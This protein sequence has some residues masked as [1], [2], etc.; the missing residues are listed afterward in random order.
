MARRLVDRQIEDLD[1]VT[2]RIQREIERGRL[3]LAYHLALSIPEALPS[4]N[5]IKLIACNYLA[6]EQASIP[7]NLSALVG[8]LVSEVETLPNGIVDRGTLLNYA[9]L[10]TSAALKPSL[11]VPGSEEVA[12]LF[13]FSDGCLAETPS[14]QALA[15]DAAEVSRRR[16]HV[17]LLREDDSRWSE[18][19]GRLRDD[20][21]DWL[22]EE[23]SRKNLYKR[24]NYVWKRMLEVWEFG[25]RASIGRLV[26]L[27]V[28]ESDDRI[29]IDKVSKITEY[30]RE[31][32]DKEIDRIDSLR[33]KRRDKIAGVSRTLLIE[34]IEKAL[35]FADRWCRLAE[36]RPDKS[37]ESQKSHADRLRNSVRKNAE[38]AL[39]EISALETPYAHEARKL[40]RGYESIFENEA[41][42]SPRPNLSLRDL[43]HG[44]LLADPDVRFDETDSV[45]DSDILQGLVDRD[46][47]DFGEA[48]VERARRKDFGGAEKTLEFAERSGQI[49]EGGLTGARK[50]IEKQQEGSR[51]ELEGRIGATRDRLDAAHAREIL[52]GEVFEELHDLLPELL[53]DRSDVDEYG[54]YSELLDLIKKEIH[55]AGGKERDRLKRSLDGLKGAS[56]EE[57]NRIE[58]LIEDDQF[59]IAQDYINR[60]KYRTENSEKLPEQGSDTKHTFDRFFPKFVEKYVEYRDETPDALA[61]VQQALKDRASAGPVNAVELSPDAA[62]DGLQL[63]EKWSDLQ[64]NPAVPDRLRDLM[65]A[66]GFKE[67]KIHRSGTE[68]TSFVLETDPVEDRSI[69]QLPDFGSRARGRYRLIVIRKYE[70]EEILW[71]AEEKNSAG[72]LPNIVIFLNVLGAEARRTLARKFNSGGYRPTI[73]F[74]EVFVAFLAAQPGS[75]RHRLRAFF[76]CAAPFSFAQPFD[77]HADEVPLEMFFG[78]EA[79]RNKIVSASGNGTHFVY[80]GRRMGKTALF[81]DIARQN[82]A[83]AP[84]ELVLRIDLRNTGIGVSK[85]AE[86]LWDKFAE[87]LQMIIPSGPDLIGEEIKRWLD[88]KKERRILL[89]VDEAD[90]FL[91]A[92]GR[93]EVKVDGEEPRRK[94]YQIV[95][96]VKSLMNETGRRFRVVFGGLHNVQ[97]TVRDSN[98]PFAHFDD[99][100][101][102]G[103]M[104]PGTDSKRIENLILGPMEAL[105]YRFDSI[106]SVIRIAAE[107]NYD[108]A[109]VQCFCM[110]LLDHL[111]KNSGMNGAL[112][113]PYTIS[114]E[115][116]DRICNSG[117]IRRRIKD[118]FMWTLHLDPRYEFLTYLIARKSFDNGS[119]RLGDLSLSQIRQDALKE[120]FAGFDL[121]P[122]FASFEVL[123][124]E[125]VGLGVLRKRTNEEDGGDK[126]Y[127]IRTR[128]LRMLLGNDN[129]IERGFADAKRRT[130]PPLF[131]PAGFRRTLNDKTPSPLTA[132]QEGRLF[133][134]QN[135]VALVFGT[136]LSGIDQVR[137]ALDWA[138]KRSPIDIRLHEDDSERR[139]TVIRD[140]KP[141]LDV[142]LADMRGAWDSDRIDEALAYVDRN[143]ASTRTIRMVFLCGPGEAWAWVKLSRPGSKRRNAELQ[144]IWLG[145]YAKDFAIDWLKE[146]EA[147]VYRDD[148]KNRDPLWPVVAGKAAGQERPQERPE[149]VGAA[150]DLAIEG[151][152]MVSDILVS[153]EVEAALRT[154]SFLDSPMN[155]DLL[156]QLSPD[157]E[158][159]EQEIDPDDARRVFEWGARLGIMH[160]VGEREGQPEYRLDAAYAK[161]LEAVFKG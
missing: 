125:M 67:V 111:R 156:A 161:G 73:V 48:A 150:V 144:D 76:D 62:G 43:L 31:N 60:I 72:V 9:V 119:S 155:M 50:E 118:M 53:A 90:D 98:A 120:W 110:E 158:G 134:P 137:E 39:E 82:R 37:T 107:A 104:L 24:A 71:E 112:G 92:D 25:D 94:K 61:Q 157:V 63:L 66:V 113:P 28:D 55:A 140:S 30:W 78:R 142:F 151:S 38:A 7:A 128:N 131:D 145:P 97:R 114:A 8:E 1:V 17:G 29:E 127:V 146:R 22:D 152:D 123:L 135:A 86:H 126:E 109:L 89:M 41:T 149:S 15:K 103:P 116:V 23:K 106:D 64:I 117:E 87:E 133:S 69:S 2:Q 141:G 35:G 36:T 136:R 12:S 79:E 47:L 26:E 14:L 70:T 34:E 21:E 46:T 159:V 85:P 148:L 80:G 10:L 132:D 56:P 18:K 91:E 59:L 153:P 52:S 11:T 81:A 19:M 5:A 45:V 49:D 95:D 42:E 130:L 101:Q 143:N 139:E 13:S 108:P 99:P 68:R 6:D 100:V 54:A 121:D 147:P 27:L 154:L 84:D 138:A 33:R 122:S 75:R 74:D 160:G 3:G 124:D 20:V 83:K 93:G 4:A 32:M 58:S 40:V 16:I 65:S 57:R 102:I 88:E 129:E 105:G 44:D 115:A 96:Q 51:Q 77:P